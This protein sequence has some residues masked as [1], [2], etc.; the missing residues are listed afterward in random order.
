MV[1]LPHTNTVILLE[2][3]CGTITEPGSPVTTL[4]LKKLIN[5]PFP[6]PIWKQSKDIFPNFKHFFCF[7][8][9]SGNKRRASRTSSSEQQDCVTAILFQT[10][11]PESRQNK[12]SS[13]TQLEGDV[14]VVNVGRAKTMDW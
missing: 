4:N 8:F 12:G 7:T 11:M 6:K 9:S 10:N 1:F 5:Q 3:Y 2:P 13:I 14:Y